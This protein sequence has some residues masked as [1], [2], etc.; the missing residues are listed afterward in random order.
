MMLAARVHGE[1]LDKLS[2][3]VSE[4]RE[5]ARGRIPSHRTANLSVLGERCDH[6]IGRRI[7]P[8]R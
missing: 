5:W 6:L 8:H 7:P 4:C 1:D 3:E 2:M